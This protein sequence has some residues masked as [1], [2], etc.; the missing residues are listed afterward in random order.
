ME[1]WISAPGVQTRN[2]FSHTAYVKMTYVKYYLRIRKMCKT[3]A[4]A[5]GIH[6]TRTRTSAY[7]KITRVKFSFFLLRD[8]TSAI[9]SNC[10]IL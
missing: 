9:N 4:R 10:N 7:V 3:C 2:L 1:H 5:S 6:K 8:K